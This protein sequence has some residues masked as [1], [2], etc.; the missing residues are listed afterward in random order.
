[1]ISK[2]NNCDPLKVKLFFQILIL[3][4]SNSETHL[5]N[6]AILLGIPREYI[7]LILMSK[8]VLEPIF[9]SDQSLQF[10]G[11]KDSINTRREYMNEKEYQSWIE[12]FTIEIL[13]TDEQLVPGGNTSNLKRFLLLKISQGGTQ[14]TKRAVLTV[15]KSLGNNQN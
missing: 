2:I 6:A 4:T 15:L 3:Y 14:M 9:V 10:F 11:A 1:M 8:R 7:S 12:S 13:K 5:A